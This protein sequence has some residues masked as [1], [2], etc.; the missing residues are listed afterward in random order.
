MKTVYLLLTILGI[1]LPYGALVPWLLTNGVDVELLVEHA[2]ANPISV[3]AWLD[4]IIAAIALLAFII[5]DS[6]VNKVKG[7]LYAIIGTLTV[8]VSFGLPLYLYLRQR[9]LGLQHSTQLEQA[10]DR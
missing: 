5:S 2:T 3:L 7:A 9:Q 1:V 10:Y 6:R 8:G 4:V